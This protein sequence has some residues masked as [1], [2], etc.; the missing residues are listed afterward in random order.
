M[1]LW[2]VLGSSGVVCALLFAASS[3]TQDHQDSVKL[4]KDSFSM[5]FPPEHPVALNQAAKK[6]LASDPAV[7]DVM[8]DDGLTIDTIPKDWFTASEVHLTSEAQADLLVMGLGISLGPYTAGFWILRKTPQ[9]YDLLLSTNSHGLE[10]LQ[11]STNGL[12]D[13]ETGLTAGGSTYSQSFKF[14]GHRYQ[15]AVP[16]QPKQPEQPASRIPEGEAHFTPEQ[17]ADYYRVYDNPDVRYLRDLFNAYLSRTGGS[18]QERQALDKWDK[19]YFRS[20][21]TVMSRENNTLG[22]TLIT[23]LFQDRPDKVFVAWV[24]PER[25]H[26][27]LALRTFDEAKFSEEDLKRIR[28]RYK[29]L[30]EDKTHAM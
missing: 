3:R 13:I 11:T 21:F 26:K 15:A 17:L 29:K 27:N 30:I 6:A 5:E 7:A 12:R 16:S 22:G 2:R 20:K 18:E 14:D 10:I 4:P 9:G 28:I 25:N 19:S 23:I 8:R 1:N 24:Y